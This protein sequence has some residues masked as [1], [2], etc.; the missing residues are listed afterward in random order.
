MAIF[1][2]EHTIYELLDKIWVSKSF[3]MREDLSE[4][5]IRTKIIN[6]IEEKYQNDP[7]FRRVLN[8]LLSIMDRVE[9][10]VVAPPTSSAGAYLAIW[11]SIGRPPED[12]TV[13]VA[14]DKDS[15]EYTVNLII[16]ELTHR[17]I[18]MRGIIPNLYDEALAYFMSFKAGFK[19]FYESYI[20]AT[21]NVFSR[22][23]PPR[24]YA[25]ALEYEATTMALPTILA[26]I[27]DRYVEAGDIQDFLVSVLRKPQTVFDALKLSA[28][29]EELRAVGCLLSIISADIEKPSWL[30][31]YGVRVRD[32]SVEEFLEALR[33][34]RV[35]T[36]FDEFEY[37]YENL[38]ALLVLPIASE[39]Y[40]PEAAR[41]ILREFLKDAK[42][43]G[44]EVY[45]YL[46]NF[47]DYPD[48]FVGTLYEA[49]EMEMI[50]KNYIDD[51]LRE[52]KKLFSKLTQQIHQ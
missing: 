47:I 12:P 28:N 21:I 25:K 5:V 11:S 9:R 43:C 10:I 7:P 4:S 38:V 8:I 36:C 42:M 48:P 23:R 2:K 32:V 39:E 14:Y 29:E 46:N 51:A 15:E 19:K 24:E 44:E 37:L 26:D 20:R 27:L 45:E 41:T 49:A 1:M 52:A 34:E 33:R 6:T 30:L 50:P 35:T 13:I 3:L 18:K 16:H 17:W 31:D 22:Y 40:G